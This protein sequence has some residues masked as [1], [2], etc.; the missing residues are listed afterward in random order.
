[1]TARIEGPF[2]PLALLLAAL[3]SLVPI[4][5]PAQSA[6]CERTSFAGQNYVTCEVPPGADLR[7]WHT[8]AGGTLYG[9]FGR[10][11]S[12]LKT[13]GK[14][15]A[16]AMN[17]GMY[18]ADRSPVGLLVDNGETQA[19]IVTQ[20]GSGNFGM[21]PNG[22]FCVGA[23]GYAVVESRAFKKNPPACRFATQSG[24]MLVID[25]ALHPR[26]LPDSDSR[27]IRN[28]V[29]VRRDGTAIFAISDDPVTFH[30][31][32]TF[33]RDGLKTPQAL[34]LDG[35]ISRLYAPALRRAD[36]GFPM[37]PIVGLALADPA[38]D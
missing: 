1:M 15:L 31:F 6:P 14:R 23:R 9:A 19:P 17:G 32:G 13:E 36:F 18:H 26:F 20:A 16:F 27:F 3:L 12:A 7:V 35:K 25:G 2:A 5:V 21:L 22:V 8:S 28:G 11:D 10:I 37:G 34:Y 38:G 24:P 33:F 30:E 4:R 29:G